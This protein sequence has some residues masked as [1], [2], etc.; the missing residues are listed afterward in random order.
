MMDFTKTYFIMYMKGFSVSLT[1]PGL[2]A[3]C[4]S[5]ARRRHEGWLENCSGNKKLEAAES[6]RESQIPIKETTKYSRG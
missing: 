2:W 5:A 1:S 4:A 3:A 6:E